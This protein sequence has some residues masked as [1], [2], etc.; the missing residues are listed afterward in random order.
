MLP[1]SVANT[2]IGKGYVMFKV[3]PKAGYAVGDIIPNTAS[4]YFDFN[5]A[6]VTNTF[7]TEFVAALGTNSFENN[8]FGFY[9]NPAK[10][11]L[12]VTSNNTIHSI[13]SI[14]IYDVL[15]KVVLT[16][17]VSNTEAQTVNIAELNAGVYMIEITSN[18]NVK[19]MKKL[20]VE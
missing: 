3:K 10:D 20:M 5:P 16:K 8:Q 18:N 7:N 6:I 12:T 11:Q 9:P 13:K 1:V 4:I 2:T 15:G 17:Q 14:V 19:V